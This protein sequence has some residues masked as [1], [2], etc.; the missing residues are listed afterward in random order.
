MAKKRAG[1]KVKP[2]R[3]AAV[4]P[5]IVESVERQHNATRPAAGLP[6]ETLAAI[7]ESTIQPMDDLVD[8]LNVR[9]FHRKC[10]TL[11]PRRSNII[12]DHLTQVCHRWR[13]VALACPRLWTSIFTG[14]P[15]YL[16]AIISRSKDTELHVN[17]LSSKK[18]PGF[19]ESTLSLAVCHLP[20]L[21]TLVIPFDSVLISIFKQLCTSTPSL[22]SLVI[23]H[24]NDGSQAPLEPLLLRGG[25]PSLRHLCLYN[26]DFSWDCKIFRNLTT[27]RISE[28]LTDVLGNM[29]VT[30]AA[31][32]QME[33]SLEVLSLVRALPAISAQDDSPIVT[34]QNLRELEFHDQIERCTHILTH[35]VLPNRPSLRIR[36]SG[37][38]LALPT[39][40]A[41]LEQLFQV[42]QDR[43]ADGG[44][45]GTLTCL[46]LNPIVGLCVHD[47]GGHSG[48]VQRLHVDLSPI[49]VNSRPAWFPL[50]R[51]FCTETITVLFLHEMH[52]LNNRAMMELFGPM[53]RSTVLHCYIFGDPSFDFVSWLF[54]LQESFPALVRLTLRRMSMTR[55]MSG[56]TLP[57]CLE[58]LLET[59]SQVRKLPQLVLR[60][61]S[62]VSP[63]II[64]KLAKYV[65][66]VSIE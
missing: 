48:L 5:P 44:G 57:D 9:N 30:L 53:N 43:L 23:W 20:R 42:L 52:Y 66:N 59:Q 33:S 47:S 36:I 51:M 40:P 31:L 16:D 63:E 22:R 24:P 1:R 18:N 3:V 2:A 13:E 17:L 14:P 8:S 55:A 64:S 6:V 4:P 60:L 38:S 54:P 26:V 19:E 35:L 10:P 50:F 7:F 41:S 46:E 12:Q 37:R 34:L 39:L 56:I 27:L 45:A 61:C 15:E 25:T 28:S 62:D 32:Q 29:S 65:G 11:L 21:R 58:A 49:S